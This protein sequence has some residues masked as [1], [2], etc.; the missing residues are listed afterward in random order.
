MAETAM[1]A[2]LTRSASHTDSPIWTGTDSSSS[3]IGAAG[4]R[5]GLPLIDC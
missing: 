2:A 5:V 4:D 1:A 3:P